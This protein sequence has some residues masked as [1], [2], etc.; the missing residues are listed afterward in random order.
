MIYYSLSFK[1]N[2]NFVSL[3]VLT[4]LLCS[5]QAYSMENDNSKE[6]EGKDS[7]NIFS[8]TGSGW[9]S[10]G[11]LCS[12]NLYE[13][14]QVENVT[15][16]FKSS[17]RIDLHGQSVSNAKETVIKAIQ[18]MQSMGEE[19]PISIHF[20]SGR[21]KHISN[22]GNRGAIFKKLPTW[23]QDEK[24]ANLIANHNQTTGAYEVFLKPCNQPKESENTTCKVLKLD[25]IQQLAELGEAQAQYLLGE[26]YSNGNRVKKDDKL[27]VQW[28]RRSANQGFEAAQLMLGY[29]CAMGMGTKY[30]PQEALKWYH[31]AGEQGVSNAFLNIGTMYD[32]GE[33]VPQST[34]NAIKYYLKAASLDNH[35]AMNVLGICYRKI[36]DDIEAVKWD[37]RAAE[38]GQPHA[39]VNLAL[40]LLEGRGVERNA[41]EA[42]KWLR[43]AAEYGIVEGQMRLGMLY[44]QGTGVPQDYYEA[45]KWYL[46]A[47][48]KDAGKPS[49]DAQW[50]LWHLYSEGKGIKQNEAIANRWL[51]R[52]AENGHPIAQLELGR[53]YKLGR[54]G[55]K[56]NSDQALKYFQLSANQD[57]GSAQYDIAEMYL[58][59]WDDNIKMDQKK[60]DYW[61]KKAAAN[62]N[63]MAQLILGIPIKDKE[64]LT[65]FAEISNDV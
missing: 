31:K 59:G 60:F 33:G 61:M 55:F 3:L 8:Q 10:T 51:I 29:M 6:T 22:K 49:S 37:R 30:N 41:M 58:Y 48:L 44:E 53:H 26:M 52:S 43:E 46:T 35:K 36:G 12:E 45:L 21:G 38:G 5:P 63:Y 39:K 11:N 25:I 16:S 13:T 47:G 50:R 65:W 32:A 62:G 14:V 4:A 54:C 17:Y 34:K 15:S 19:K 2:L 24:V 64:L 42:L 27:A 28:L 18:Q 7:R 23:L 9:V 56:R 40:A 1:K 20:I 57:N